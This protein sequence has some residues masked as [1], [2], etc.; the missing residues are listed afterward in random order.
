MVRWL[1]VVGLTLLSAV[2]AYAQSAAVMPSARQQFLDNSG[3]V[4]AGCT[5]TTYSS[6]TTTPLTTYSDAALTVA[7][8]NPI[9][10][11]SAGRPAVSGAEVNIYL[12]QVSYKFVLATSAAV[13]L[14]TADAV[15]A[16][17]IGLTG[18]S[19]TG[20]VT[21]QVDTDNNSVN[22][23]KFLNGAG[24]EKV[25][26]NESGAVQIDST[27][28]IGDNTAADQAMLLD[29]GTQ[30]YHLGVQNATNSLFMGRGT[31]VGTT[32]A[33]TVTSAGA[34]TLTGAVDVTSTLTAG[35]S[36]RVDTAFETAA[37]FTE[38]NVGGGG[39]A[40]AGQGA[41]LTTSATISSSTV[42]SWKVIDAVNN[43]GLFTVF[44]S[45][46]STTLLIGPIGTDLQAFVGFG[47]PTIGGAG[48]TYTVNHIG[49]KIVRAASGSTELFATV[50]GG[51]ETASAALT[52]LAANDSLDLFFRVISATSAKFYWR[53]NGSAWSAATELTTNI[54][55]LATASSCSVGISNAGV[56]TDSALWVHGASFSR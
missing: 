47:T 7:N 16:T 44:P 35:P 29:G 52:T 30:D 1:L 15:P 4:C 17:N 13:T 34:I 23:F 42:I 31:T 27:L 11:N 25:S 2:P 24:S 10:M 41:D 40:F 54:P 12:S 33:M 3:N 20:D 39:T 56:A 36:I 5:L 50:A 51:T 53:K 14:W 48:Y 21:L 32:P 22:T 28:T 37:R 45:E 46:F 8:P 19:N 43:G 26:M 9:V 49:F 6:G 18:V 55:T 38:T